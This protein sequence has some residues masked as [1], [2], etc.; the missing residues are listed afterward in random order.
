MWALFLCKHFVGVSRFAFHFLEALEEVNNA[1]RTPEV[2]ADLTA[3]ARDDNEAHGF[4]FRF[5]RA[6]MALRFSF[7]FCPLS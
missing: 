4:G 2:C 5:G 7:V 3:V 1:G 6:P